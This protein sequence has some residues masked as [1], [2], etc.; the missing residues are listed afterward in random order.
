MKFT[1]LFLS[2]LAL[3][4]TLVPSAFGA[5]LVPLEDDLTDI[6]GLVPDLIPVIEAAE[7]VQV[8]KSLIL[9]ASESLVSEELDDLSY[10][11]DFG[12]GNRQ[13]GVEVVHSYVDSGEYEVTL[14]ISNADFT[15][16]KSQSIFAYDRSFV[17][18]SNVLS[19][20]ER[21]NQFVLEAREQGI[22][23]YW[24]KVDASIS[25]FLEEELLERALLDLVAP[26]ESSDAFLIWTE[27]S[28]GLT[29]LPKVLSQ[30][31][32]PDFLEGKDVFFLSDQNFKSLG[33][34]AR[35]VF[36]SVKPR[37]IVLTR[38]ESLLVLLDG[39][40]ENFVAT[41][42]LR[43][44][45]YELVDDALQLR[46]WN[47]LHFFV[48]SMI[49]RGVP[50]STIQ[51]ILILPV[52]VTVVAFMKQVIG[53]ATLGVYTPSIL[54]LS[55]I[56]LDLFYGLLILV[57][58]LLIGTLARLI[59]RRYRLLYIPRMAIVLCIAAI[60]I[61]FIMFLVAQFN[62]SSVVG[63]AIFP[64]LIMTTMVEKFVS[65]QSGRGLKSA[66]ILFFEVVLVAVL[67]YFVAEW[68]WLKVVILGNP[69][70]ILL[71]L[72]ANVILGRWSGLRAV[73]VFRFRELIRYAEE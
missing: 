50:T 60:T 18:L 63:I 8:G 54:A 49:E 32:S 11:W 64:M 51:L 25:T 38:P 37:Q 14:T 39:G 6:E 72:L 46:P 17:L 24:S 3:F 52:I 26:I 7:Q 66:L 59:L 45:Q 70:L 10:Q 33:N 47:V 53:L 36:Q 56:A 58:I 48:N 43:G 73:E 9:D 55:F 2:S 65:V 69:E 68:N 31:T 44:I 22:Y 21:L 12:D 27:D 34:I 62:A 4:F 40:T 15:L 5:S 13:E 1:S 42:D 71:F 20:E 35:G 29:V 67:C 28:T 41:L 19:H 23:V 30:T 16:K 57:S 61:L